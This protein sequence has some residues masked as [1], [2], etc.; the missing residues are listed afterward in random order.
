MCG[1]DSSPTPQNDSEMDLGS[2]EALIPRGE[3][4][5][6]D[7]KPFLPR[8]LLQ[9]IICAHSACEGVF[10]DQPRLQEHLQ[11]RADWLCLRGIAETACAIL[12]IRELAACPRC[13]AMEHPSS[14]E[15]SSALLSLPAPVL[16]DKYGWQPDPVPWNGS[17]GRADSPSSGRT[18]CIYD[19]ELDL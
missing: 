9:E 11:C 10:R 3:E 17:P 18:D 5:S 14:G 8:F 6:E 16:I 1:L 7:K 2:P 19:S 12:P 13:S 15:R 4:P